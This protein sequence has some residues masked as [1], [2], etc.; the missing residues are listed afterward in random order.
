MRSD[1]AGTAALP[2]AGGDRAGAIGQEFAALEKCMDPR[3]VLELLERFERLEAGVAIVESHDV[4][5]ID[6][7]V[8]Q[9]IDEAAAIRA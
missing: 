3:M 2:A 6:A 9:V 5:N 4:T 1:R 8:V 7:V